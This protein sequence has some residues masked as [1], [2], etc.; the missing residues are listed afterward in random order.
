MLDFAGRDSQPLVALGN[1]VRAP[2]GSLNAAL[3]RAGDAYFVPVRGPLAGRH[4]VAFMYG[5]T[6]ELDLG[7]QADALFFSRQVSPLQAPG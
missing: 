7:A 6:A 4:R 3:A 2:R 5:S 1:R